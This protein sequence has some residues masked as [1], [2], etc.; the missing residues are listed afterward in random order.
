MTRSGARHTRLDA[1][2]RLSS[3][4]SKSY[5]PNS[6]QMR[7][8]SCRRRQLSLRCKTSKLKHAKEWKI[9]NFDYKI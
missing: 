2:Y 7:D 6:A 1:P 4:I 8:M 3:I 5:K 9:L